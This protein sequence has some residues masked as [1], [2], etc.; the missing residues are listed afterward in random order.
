[1]DRNNG[2]EGKKSQ[3][4]S[5]KRPQAREWGRLKI[6]FYDFFHP[7]L[8]NWLLFYAVSQ[9]KMFNDLGYHNLEKDFL[10]MLSRNDGISHFSVAKVM[11]CGGSG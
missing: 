10:S 8:A 11:E 1:M 4:R 3:E 9:T 2:S 7:R 6:S 5:S